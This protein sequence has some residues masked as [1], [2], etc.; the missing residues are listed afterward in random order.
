MSRHRWSPWGAL[1]C[2]LVMT[3]P[4]AA[5]PVPGES[6]N[7]PLAQV[8]AKSV[9]VAQLKGFE[10]T[11]ERLEALLKSAMPDFADLANQ[12]IK[13]A[14]EQGLEGRK[15][16]AVTKDG[17]IFVVFTE[18]PNANTNVPKMAVL[19]PVKNY[20]DFRDGVLKDAER[21]ELKAD[22]AGYESTQ[23]MGE[24]VYFIDRKNGYAAVTPDADV[25]A[26]L[27]KKY[28]GID[29]K[30][31]KAVAKALLGSDLSVYVDM[32]AVNKE[33]GDAIKQ[34]QSQLEQA[35]D[36]MPD[37]GTADMIK[38]VYAPIFQAVGDSTAVVLAADLR[39]EGLLLHAEVAVP[40]D[41]K[42]NTLLKAWK[43]VPATDLA[44]L[45]DR[46]MIYSGMA[47]SPDVMKAFGSYAY[48]AVDPDSEEGKAV[49]KLVGEM[50]EAGPHSL[51]SASNLPAA[52]IMVS[53]YDNP[54]KA[55]EAQ[56]KLFKVL[57]EGSTF[58]AVLKSAPE[59]KENAKK[60]AG[61]DLASVGMK[62][63]LEK[64]VEKQGAAM[65]AEQKKAMIEYMRSML[66][67]GTD[68]WFGTDGKVVVQITAKGWDEARDLLDRYQKGERTVGSTEAY[69]DAVK[70]L[71]A[72]NS[73]LM[74]ADVPQLTETM[75]KS[76]V[77]MLQGSGLPIPIPPGFEKPSVNPKTSFGGLAITLESGRGGLDVWLS[78]TSINDVYK[79]YVERLIKPN[80]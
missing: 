75:V 3:L 78:A 46:S 53:K 30:L 52:G 66:G 69:K 15:I 33:H 5:A 36:A 73:I 2:A 11:R 1:A 23:I 76:V 37:K 57:K 51:L 6:D 4:A 32:A 22:P 10:R 70:H 62:W 29:G 64:T 13:D 48:G 44:K 43:T 65:T 19:V 67:D 49:K 60:H 12:K 38:R 80:F 9:I 59:I 28:D 21:K 68:L 61:F 58:G 35:L 47:Y 26:T 50:A 27:A 74:L 63:D 25:A 77:T 31:S 8:P 45:P 14:I 20:K 41:S 71:P 16:D 39:P 34:G 7:K 17:H 72:E 56:M 24:A 42:T 79:M 54:A 18:L 55:V 40:P